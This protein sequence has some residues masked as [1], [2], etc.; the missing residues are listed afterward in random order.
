MKKRRW[1][2]IQLLV[3][4]GYNLMRKTL[5]KYEQINYLRELLCNFIFDCR[6]KS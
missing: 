5:T 6:I 3:E 4:K 1:K 2:N